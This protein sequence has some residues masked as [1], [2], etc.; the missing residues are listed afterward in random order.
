MISAL[1]VVPPGTTLAPKPAASKDWDQL[2]ANEKKLFARQM[3]IFAGSVNMR[4]RRSAA[5]L[6]E[7]GGG[8]RK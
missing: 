6:I 7:C 4:T 1:G 3:E 5:S 2:N 8:A